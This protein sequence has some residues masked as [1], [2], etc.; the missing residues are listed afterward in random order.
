MCLQEPFGFVTSLLLLLSSVS[1][2]LSLIKYMEYHKDTC[3]Q[4][5]P[6]TYGVSLVGK[7]LLIWMAQV[8]CVIWGRND[9]S[10]RSE[11]S[12]PSGGLTS[13]DLPE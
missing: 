3:A 12:K 10:L 7:A 1:L 6:C 5:L 11:F 4:I 13:G 2:L 9:E 8:Y